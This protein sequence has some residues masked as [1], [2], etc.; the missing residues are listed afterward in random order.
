VD[1]RELYQEVILDHNRSPKNFKEIEKPTGTA[2]GHNPLCGDEITVSLVI[3]DGTIEDVGFQGNGCAISQASAS[4]MTAAVKGK[5]VAEARKLFGKFHS[6]VAGD[7]EA[8][9][10]TMGGLAA[11][12]GVREFPAR[13][14][15]A[16]LSWHTLNAALDEE[17]ET[18]VTE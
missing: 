15:C 12:G 3:E 5:S 13:V 16:S 8:D 2:V 11:F 14:K 9:R 10:A 1:T 18:V 4:M 17:A 6:M 7:G